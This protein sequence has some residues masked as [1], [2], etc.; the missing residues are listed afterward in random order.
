MSPPGG[1]ICPSSC[2]ISAGHRGRGPCQER[3]FLSWPTSPSYHPTRTRHQTGA[4]PSLMSPFWNEMF[5][6]LDAQTPGTS[7]SCPTSIP[8]NPGLSFLSLTKHLLCSVTT[9]KPASCA[10]TPP[11][12]PACRARLV[13]GKPTVRGPTKRGA[14]MR[15]GPGWLE[16]P[17]ASEHDWQV[18]GS[19]RPGGPRT[20]FG[21][22]RRARA[23]LLISE[24]GVFPTPWLRPGEPWGCVMSGRQSKAGRQDVN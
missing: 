22:P 7:A 17:E 6:S 24:G 12:T 4:K 11:R 23:H 2:G 13:S 10:S 21:P 15:V 8:H 1:S 19:T 3:S 20:Q 9:N 18:R 14:K 16:L 5:L